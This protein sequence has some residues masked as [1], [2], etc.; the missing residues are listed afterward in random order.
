MYDYSSGELESYEGHFGPIYCVRFGPEGELSSD[1][2][3]E[4]SPETVA[5]P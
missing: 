1:S 2:G 3:D 4:T 5:N